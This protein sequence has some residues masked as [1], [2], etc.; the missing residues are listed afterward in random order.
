MCESVSNQG[1][2][3][4]RLRRS[5]SQLI[6]HSNLPKSAGNKIKLKESTSRT[7]QL[8]KESMPNTAKRNNKD[9]PRR[10]EKTLSVDD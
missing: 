4:Q 7:T 1:S 10:Y 6:V 8:S 5:P 3:G 2:A 9:Q